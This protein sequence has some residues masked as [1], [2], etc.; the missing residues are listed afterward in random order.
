MK[1]QLRLK[2]INEDLQLIKDDISIDDPILEELP[3]AR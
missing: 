2:K 3:T 1:Y